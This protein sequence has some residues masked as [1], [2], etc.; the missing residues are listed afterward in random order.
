MITITISGP[1][2]EG[3]SIIAQAI[4]ELLRHSGAEEVTLVNDDRVQYA[5]GKLVDLA[6]RRPVKVRIITVSV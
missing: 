4:D 1:Q 5:E 2:G 3:K 6:V